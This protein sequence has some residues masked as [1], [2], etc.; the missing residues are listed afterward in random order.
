MDSSVQI[1]LLLVEDD[2]VDQ[3][4]FK[5]EIRE[6][7]LPIDYKIA[8]SVSTALPLLAAETFEVV[9]TDH[10]LGDGTAFDI[11]KRCTNIPVIFLTGQGD[12]ELAV[13]AMKAGAFDYL[14]K[15]C[16]RLYLK[17]LPMVIA[18]AAERRRSA[19][20]L[21]ETERRYHDLFENA[22]DLIQVTDAQGKMILVNP[23]WN[24]TLGF[25][26]LQV[27]GRF[28]DEFVHPD[29]QVDVDNA[30]RAALEGQDVKRDFKMVARDGSTLIVEGSFGATFSEDRPVA[31]RSILHDVTERK[32]IEAALAEARDAALD[33]ARLKSTFL[34]NMSHEIRTPMNG[35]IGMTGLLLDT[36][37]SREQREF[38]DTVKSCAESLL[39]IL[40]DI[41]DFSKIEAGKLRFETVDFDL[42]NVIESTVEVLAARSEQKK[43]EL[44]SSIFPDVPIQLKGDPGRLRQVLT[45][46]IGNAIKF[47]ETGEVIVRVKKVSETPEDVRIRFSVTDTGIGIPLEAQ[48]RIFDAFVQADASTTRRFGG[49]GLG[50]AISKQ[51]IEMM[52]GEIWFES[53]EGKG[54]VFTF[55]TSLIKQPGAAQLPESS[56]NISGTH[57]LVVDDNATNRRILHHQLRSWGAF[58][59]SAESGEEALAVLRHARD[60]GE[61]FDAAILD[62]QMPG[63]DGIMLASCIKVEPGFT[64]LPIM[65]LTS[66][67]VLNS[68]EIAAAGITSCLHKPVR[69]AS[70]RETI[71]RLIRKGQDEGEQRV[72]AKV[73]SIQDLPA[74]ASP[75]RILVAEDNAVNQKVILMQ[76]K[77]L[78]YSA[79]AVTNGVEALAALSRQPYDCILMDC[80][81]PQMDGYKATEELRKRE[82]G[83]KHTWIVAMTA[84]AME[85]D[86]ERCLLAGMDDYLSKPVTVENLKRA[87]ERG[88]RREQEPML[89]AV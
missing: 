83:S 39:T 40:N 81:M 17:K 36:E 35:I 3:M 60:S 33:S 69:Q 6:Q 48:A 46:L 71:Y 25:T 20:A 41:L 64:N 12:E 37:L 8:S 45:N 52:G 24:K 58:D 1:H 79:D 19:R 63:M 42:R 75:A 56:A 55:E 31:V 34:A 13:R 53:R 49:S 18:N 50:L 86:R 11:V 47:T 72:P 70:L 78:G 5:R 74:T 21:A 9:I 4:A 26:Q 62:M 54:S 65:M 44:A 51:L 77:R 28:F 2:T 68:R 7:R 10:D 59:V 89:Q 32:Q 43:I 80:Q 73:L 57:I 84:H 82:G 38:T 23:A 67:G 85:G 16:D 87:L 66:R 61:T 22:N 88:L 29:S 76:L 15:D 30:F 27:V 14:I